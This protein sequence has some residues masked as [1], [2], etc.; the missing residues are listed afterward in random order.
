[1]FKGIMSGLWDLD[2]WEEAGYLTGRILFFFSLSSCPTNSHKVQLP[3]LLS[4]YINKQTE[5]GKRGRQTDK[6]TKEILIYKTKV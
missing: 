5:G 2:F 4:K 1:M 3:Q 6:Q